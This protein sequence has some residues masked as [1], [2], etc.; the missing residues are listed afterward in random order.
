VHPLVEASRAA[1]ELALD[2][3]DLQPVAREDG[4]R[5][6][7]REPR[8]EDHHVESAAGNRLFHP[9]AARRGPLPRQATT[10][11]AKISSGTADTQR[12]SSPAEAALK[13]KGVTPFT[14]KC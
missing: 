6:G 8:A 9:Q 10:A 2:Q 13:S 14:G 3:R 7:T 11:P 5:S 12:P 4:C 1:G